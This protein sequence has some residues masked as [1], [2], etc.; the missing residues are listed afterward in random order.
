MACTTIA[1]AVSL[2]KLQRALKPF[3]GFQAVQDGIK[4]RGQGGKPHILLR[5]GSD[6]D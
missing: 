2:R 3:G 6:A 4:G 5:V 1:A